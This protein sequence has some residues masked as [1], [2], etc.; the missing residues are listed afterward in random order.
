MSNAKLTDEELARIE[1]DLD[2]HGYCDHERVAKLL[3]EIREHRETRPTCAQCHEQRP[4]VC[5][6]NYEGGDAAFACA[7]CCGHGNE[8]GW[9]CPIAE[10]DQ[11]LNRYVA[12]A[13]RLDNCIG[14]LRQLLA[15]RVQG[16]TADELAGLRM[17]RKAGDDLTD[18]DFQRAPDGPLGRAA[19]TALD[20]LLAAHGGGGAS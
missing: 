19:M 10:A 17:L 11:A 16:F 3:A 9:C 13:V 14:E 8:D 1:R 20:K 2:E 6:G 5:V 7:S 4:A 15:E 18:D 12:S